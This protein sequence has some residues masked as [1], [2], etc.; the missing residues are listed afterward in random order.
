MILASLLLALAARFPVSLLPEFEAAPPART[1]LRGM[2]RVQVEPFGDAFLVVSSHEYIYWWNRYAM[3]V[4]A[5]GEPLLPEAIDLGYGAVGNTGI[6][7]NGQTALI[8]SGANGYLSGV[9]LDRSGA[10]RTIEIHKLSHAPFSPRDNGGSP[11]VI[12][13]GTQFLVI[14]TL[15]VPNGSALKRVPILTRVSESGS[16]LENDIPGGIDA[17]LAVARN[18]ITILGSSREFQ[19]LNGTSLGEITTLPE[20]ESLADLAAGDDGFLVLATRGESELRAYHL[21]AAGRRDRAPFSLP[22][23]SGTSS[24]AWDGNA[25]LVTN[26]SGAVLRVTSD[27]T[28][29]DT[30]TG[31]PATLVASNGTASIVING[32]DPVRTARLGSTQQHEINIS[33]IERTQPVLAGDAVIWKDERGIWRNTIGSNTP[34]LFA[35]NITQFRDA[36]SG[37]TGTL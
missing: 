35:E 2:L 18:R 30:I 4:S 12:W 17:A 8:V 31:A 32:A 34:Q 28:L 22:R 5:D 36:A 9:L 19:M 10:A 6:A 11:D 33:R 21:D 20:N 23:Q 16:I 7:T 29:L 13:D 14:S 24:V 27:G 15:E 26:G 3:I 1:S 25:W 37:A